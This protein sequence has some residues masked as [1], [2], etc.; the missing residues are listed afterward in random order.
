MPCARLA[1]P[2]GSAPG[3]IDTDKGLKHPFHPAQMAACAFN[4]RASSQSMRD[5][6]QELALKFAHFGIDRRIRL[7]LKA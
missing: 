3:E 6:S 2:S 1:A 5:R 4:V 7:K